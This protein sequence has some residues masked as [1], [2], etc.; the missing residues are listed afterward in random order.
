MQNKINQEPKVRP[1]TECRRWLT[2]R[3]SLRC[4]LPWVSLCRVETD[5]YG[6]HHVTQGLLALPNSAIHLCRYPRDGERRTSLPVVFRELIVLS[7]RCRCGLRLCSLAALTQ[8][9]KPASQ[10]RADAC[11]WRICG[12]F[13]VTVRRLTVD[14]V[15]SLGTSSKLSLV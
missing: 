2:H 13:S 7:E 4:R 9:M 3:L 11:M 12:C 5:S 15:P 10:L 6:A 14:L 1:Y 8:H